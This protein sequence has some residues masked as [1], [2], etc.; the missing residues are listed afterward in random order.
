MGIE[1]RALR[2][3]G[4]MDLRLESFELPEP[5]DDEMLAEII[6]DSLCMSSHKAAKQGEE[7]TRVPRDISRNP[8]IVGHEFSGRLLRVGK[9]WRERFK[10]GDHFTVQPVLN[11]KGS[12][13]TIGYSFTTVGGN[14][15]YAIIPSSIIENDCLLT[16]EGDA[17]FK[18]SL[19][20]PMGCIIAACK[21]QYHSDAGSYMHKMG[22][23]KGGKTALLGAAGP[24]GL[25]LL[26]YLIHGPN[27]PSL[28]A[29]TDVSQT[30]L[31]YAKR[32]ITVRDADLRGIGLT[33]L[34]TSSGA[35]VQELLDLSGGSGYDDVFIMAPV[36]DLIIQGDGILRGDGCLNFFAGPIS[37][38]FH[39]PLNYYNVHY[40]GTHVVG[41]SGSSTE[42]MREALQLIAKNEIKPAM[43]ITHVGGLTA[44]KDAILN[45]P[46]LPG[47][48][49]LIYNQIDMPLMAISK[50]REKR[51]EVPLFA[52]LSELCEGARGLW[53]S[54]AEQVLLEKASRIKR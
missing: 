20:E 38:D 7:H 41:T 25:G 2:L 19:C 54:M 3:Y 45:L 48:K 6:C 13:N 4:K 40:K 8:V 52:E 34:N 46:N 28:L 17:Y 27:R 51:D 15:T 32:L 14:T 33:Y 44:A 5:A 37:S 16:Y 18:A 31:D 49:K 47:G 12:L 29:V 21:A 23:V 39:A 9:R 10:T 35:P 1:T 36:S 30:R 43:M 26:D 22:I 11:S 53:N 42:D 50:F 24:M